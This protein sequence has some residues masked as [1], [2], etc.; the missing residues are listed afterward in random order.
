MKSAICLSNTPLFDW[1][2]HFLSRQ[3]QGAI[4]ELNIEGSKARFRLPDGR[5]VAVIVLPKER[6]VDVALSSVHEVAS[7]DSSLFREVVFAIEPLWACCN[8]TISTLRPLHTTLSHICSVPHIAQYSYWGELYVKLFSNGWMLLERSGLGS[9]KRLGN[10][11]W[12]EV[13]SSSE[14]DHLAK[15]HIIEKYLTD[16]DIWDGGKGRSE[17]V[18]MALLKQCSMEKSLRDLA[19]WRQ[20]NK[21][22]AV[23]CYSESVEAARLAIS[24]FGRNC[25]EGYVC[26]IISR[27]EDGV[28]WFW[29][30]GSR[31][32]ALAR[33]RDRILVGRVTWGVVLH[34][35]RKTQKE[36]VATM[37]ILNSCAEVV[38]CE[39][40]RVLY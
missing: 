23:N 15:A 21:N 37:E 31:L 4:K 5:R 17:A 27:A 29:V 10:G 20:E 16:I 25:R 24:D 36:I 33:S 3:R 1:E 40:L 2:N 38:K 39:N 28:A 19:L 35:L 13:S 7:Y 14:E 11:V 6:K 32:D 18:Q 26:S 12:V 22:D 8:E 30:K 9:V 34:G